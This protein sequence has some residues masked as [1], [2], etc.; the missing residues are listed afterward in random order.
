MVPTERSSQPRPGNGSVFTAFTTK[1][2]RKQCTNLG[3]T[4]TLLQPPINARRARN[5]SEQQKLRG[6]RA[7]QPHP[8][9]T[10]LHRPRR[11]HQQHHQLLLQLHRSPSKSNSNSNSNSNRRGH[12]GNSSSKGMGLKSSSNSSKSSNIKSS[13]RT[14]TPRHGTPTRTPTGPAG[15]PGHP[16]DQASPA[17]LQPLPARLA[18]ADGTSL[19]PLIGQVGAAAEAAVAP[20]GHL[21]SRGRPATGG[22]IGHPMHIKAAGVL[23]P[24]QG[25]RLRPR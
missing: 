15:S 10:N 4:A 18:S 9:R 25:L 14:P 20:A 7:Q 21:P 3:T 1:P 23:G 5:K 17:H 13:K 6:R 24:D 12:R 2:V 11:R 8:W 19:D 16:P 22:A